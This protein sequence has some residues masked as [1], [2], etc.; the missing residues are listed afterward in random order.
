MEDSIAGV[1]AARAGQFGMVIGV[2]RV[3]H[4][5]GLR[6]KGA[7]WV[8]RDLGEVHLTDIDSWFRQHKSQLPSAL[9]RMD[10]IATRLSNK[11][12]A[13]FLDYDG[14]LTP[15][16]EHPDNAFMSEEMREVVRQLAAVT[17]VAVVSGRDRNKVRD[18]VK[19]DKL[20]YAG[21]HGFDIA[22]PNQAQIQYEEGNRF[23]PA[24]DK[25]QKEISES[26]KGINGS[27][28]ERTAFSISVEMLMIG[29][30]MP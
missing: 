9:D 23:L 18:F 28:V 19:L 27:L 30:M 8:V 22:G 13:L 4:G 15:I 11:K 21:S 1:E 14:T 16:V 25:A 26:V 20:V 5:N 6:E 17:P 24:L 29:R 7:H 2:D 12:A 3:N 10:E